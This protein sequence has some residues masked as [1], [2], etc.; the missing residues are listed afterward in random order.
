MSTTLPHPDR[1]TLCPILPQH[2]AAATALYEEAFPEL[3]RRPTDAWHGLM[4][5]ENNFQTHAICIDGEFAGFITSWK[6]ADFVY[7]EH[8]AIASHR[9]NG[10]WGG[11][12]LQAFLTQNAQWPVVLEVE[13]PTTSMA[14]RRIAFYER[15]GFSMLRNPYLQPPYREGDE[16]LPLRLMTT[17]PEWGHDNFDSITS[18]IHRTVYNWPRQA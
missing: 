9:R 18:T 7:V 17:H 3:E 14:Q 6:P 4:R 2:L 1:L 8:F 15:H 12:A 5:N 13:E 16:M 11:T 10:G